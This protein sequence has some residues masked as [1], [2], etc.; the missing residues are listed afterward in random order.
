ME[1]ETETVWLRWPLAPLG[2][3][4]R[5]IYRA[6]VNPQVLANGI[7]LNRLARMRVQNEDIGG[8]ASRRYVEPD[9]QVV[10][11][12]AMLIALFLPVGVFTMLLSGVGGPIDTA[13][14]TTVAI[15]FGLAWLWTMG[16][17]F[18]A[19][20]VLLTVQHQFWPEDYDDPPT[21]G[22]P[23]PP[24]AVNGGGPEFPHR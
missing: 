14:E 19:I 9:Q 10:L 8:D 24:S 23:A 21:T 22:E 16:F 1:F 15:V 20:V 2:W 13:K 4:G 7:A 17:G 3:L 5:G 12:N 18:S 6:F 11:G